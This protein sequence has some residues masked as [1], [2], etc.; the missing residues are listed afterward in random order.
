[1]REGR[2]EGEGSAASVGPLHFNLANFVLE[3]LNTIGQSQLQNFD[4]FKTEQITLQWGAQNVNSKSGSPMWRTSTAGM[5]PWTHA[6][7]ESFTTPYPTILNNSLGT[8]DSMQIDSSSNPRC[9]H[10]ATHAAA[11]VHK[12]P[13][14]SILS[15]L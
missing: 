14:V 4:A 12:S 13:E 8:A 15:H 2:R 3:N 1:M 9:K 5:Q 6:R 7:V 10:C 11:R